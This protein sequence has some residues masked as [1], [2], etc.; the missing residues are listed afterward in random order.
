MESGD[1]PFLRALWQDPRVGDWLGGVRDE[2][3]TRRAVERLVAGWDTDDF[4][5][6][7]FFDRVTG[8]FVGYCGLGAV[9]VLDRD[10]IELLYAVTPDRWGDGSATE[11]AASVIEYGFDVLGLDELVAFTMTTN[12]ASRRVMERSGLVFERDF[13]RAGLL[14]ALYRRQ[15]KLPA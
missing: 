1:E 10:E 3:H 4:G 9:R 6:W 8:A 12:L 5:V 7:L 14:H 2:V 15:A 11:M 13:E